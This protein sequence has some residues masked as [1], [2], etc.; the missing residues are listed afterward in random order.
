MEWGGGWRVEGS[1][2]VGEVFIRRGGVRARERE[3]VKVSR[4]PGEAPTA[5]APPTRCCRIASQLS[6]SLKSSLGGRHPT[7]SVSENEVTHYELSRQK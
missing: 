3:A 4:T 5:E 2:V 1:E 6:F 7:R